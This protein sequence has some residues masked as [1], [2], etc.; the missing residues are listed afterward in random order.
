[1]L[2]IQDHAQIH[3]GFVL[4]LHSKG[5]SNPADETKGKWRRL[6]MRELVE[7]WEDCAIQLPYY[8][9]IGVNWREMPPI[10]HFCGNFWY[11]STKYV[12]TLADFEYYYDHPHYQIWDAV[13]NKRLG[14]EFWISSSPNEPRMLSLAYSNVDF[15]N[16]EFWRNK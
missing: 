16:P 14:C 4:Y 9:I 6:M 12:R 13:H 15:C 10:S 8:D 3:S 11:A 1:M 7:K 5:V 2:A